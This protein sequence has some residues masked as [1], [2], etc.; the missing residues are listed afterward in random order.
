MPKRK[1]NCAGRAVLQTRIILMTLQQR[2]K[3]VLCDGLD[4][5]HKLARDGGQWFAT[6]SPREPVDLRR[7]TEILSTSSYI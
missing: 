7:K 6:M 3:A 5:W 1:K 2:K 4:C